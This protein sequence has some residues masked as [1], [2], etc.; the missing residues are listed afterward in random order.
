MSH[1]RGPERLAFWRE[2]LSDYEGRLYPDWPAVE[3]A[4]ARLFEE[5]RERIGLGFSWQNLLK[6]A[7]DAGWIL[8]AVEGLRLD[9]S[10]REDK[11]V[12]RAP[13]YRPSALAERAQAPIWV[14]PP[15]TA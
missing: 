5:Q 15:R 12:T 8:P 10:A 13:L 4:F 14:R 9:L 11:P 1:L 2:I 3:E 6:V 7:D